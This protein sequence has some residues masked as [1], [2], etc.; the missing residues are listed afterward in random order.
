MRTYILF[1][2]LGLPGLPRIGSGLNWIVPCVFFVF[3]LLTS[4]FPSGL[5]VAHLPPPYGAAVC[6]LPRSTRDATCPSCIAARAPIWARCHTNHRTTTT[7][8]RLPVPG[9]FTV[10]CGHR[11]IG[12]VVGYCTQAR[13]ASDWS[14][15]CKPAGASHGACPCPRAAWLAAS[16][17]RAPICQPR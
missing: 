4:V 14:G 1:L 11:R 9:L 8:I 12:P 16:Y 17:S 2:H 15:A 10:N 3:G 7:R 6:N 5:A 13:T